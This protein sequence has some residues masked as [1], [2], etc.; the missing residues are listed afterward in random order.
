MI[1]V[2]VGPENET[3]AVHKDL[4]KLH[5]GLIREYLADGTAEDRKLTLAAVKP[6]MFADFVSWIYNGS[7]LQDVAE[8]AKEEE[9]ACTQLWT[10]GELLKV[11]QLPYA[12]NMDEC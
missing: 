9:D 12:H 10:M 8:A 7:Y 1:T 6:A 2:F 3:F 5:S 11:V 4:L